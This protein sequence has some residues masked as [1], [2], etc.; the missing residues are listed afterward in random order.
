MI[1]L[2]FELPPRRHD[3]LAVAH[4]SDLRSIEG[5]T[6]SIGFGVDDGQIPAD[7]AARGGVLLKSQELRMVTIAAR[8]TTQDRA[9]EQRLTPERNQA[10]RIEMRRMERPDTQP[11]TLPLPFALCPLP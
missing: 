4:R 5:I 7:C 11:L 10:L 8:R 1:P 9:R 6:T 2:E 3:T